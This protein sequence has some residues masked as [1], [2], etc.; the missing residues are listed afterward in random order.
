[1]IN[2]EADARSNASS[3]KKENRNRSVRS[4][5]PASCLLFPLQSPPAHTNQRKRKWIR[6]AGMVIEKEEER[7]EEETRKKTGNEMEPPNAYL[8]IACLL[9]APLVLPVSFFL[10]PPIFHLPS[11]SL[12]C[13]FLCLPFLL[14]ARGRIPEEL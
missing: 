11:H 9:V 1:M 12:P 4:Y 14:R 2:T 10:L 8:G 5:R 3:S 6:G 7:K 13:S